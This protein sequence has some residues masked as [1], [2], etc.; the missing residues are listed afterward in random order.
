VTR[1]DTAHAVKTIL[2][3]EDDPNLRTL[4]KLALGDGYRVVEAAD[5]PTAL[6]LIGAERPDLVVLDLMLPGRSGLEILSE[7]RSGSGNEHL[8][9]IVISAW[10]HS[11]GAAVAAGAD[12]FIAKPFDPIDLEAAVAELLNGEDGDR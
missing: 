1:S 12:R 3:C 7:I 8:P 11:D 4:V 6:D 10:S 2:V 9:V 5:G